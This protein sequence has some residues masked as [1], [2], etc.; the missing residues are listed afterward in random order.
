MLLVTFGL[1]VLEDENG[2]QCLDSSEIGSQTEG[3]K[4]NFSYM[5]GLLSFE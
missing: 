2:P 4:L 3:E 1:E 5:S